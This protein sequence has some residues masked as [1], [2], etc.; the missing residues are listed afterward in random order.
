MTPLPA[1]FVDLGSIDDLAPGELRWFEQHLLFLVRTETEFLALSQRS[2]HRGCRLTTVDELVVAEP[3]LDVTFFGPDVVF[4]DGCHGSN[5]QLDG[6]KVGG[7]SGRDMYRYRV[8]TFTGRVIVDLRLAIPGPY[9]GRDAA[10]EP[11]PVAGPG[12]VDDVSSGWLSAA[13][14]SRELILDVNN[15]PLLWP[16]G[17]FHDPNTGLVSLPLTVGYEFGVLEIGSFEA[18]QRWDYDAMDVIVPGEQTSVGVMN[19]YRSKSD[20]AAVY[21]ELTLPDDSG[22]RLSLG[23]QSTD[24]E[25]AVDVLLAIVETHEL[26]E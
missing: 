9:V 11:V 6:S 3:D 17:A 13:D 7:P 26:E 20:T 12:V 18:M 23:R 1:G 2:P 24:R 8:D 10:S 5:F 22:V 25:T 4:H 16:L 15:G 21:V 14:S 19:V